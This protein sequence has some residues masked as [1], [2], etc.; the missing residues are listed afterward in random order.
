M[1]SLDTVFFSFFTLPPLLDTFKNCIF[2]LAYFN[3]EQSL[4]VINCSLYNV[5]IFHF[6]WIH[7][8]FASMIKYLQVLDKIVAITF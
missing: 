1:A 8:I 3:C 4:Y 2:S 7:L 6:T 5:Y